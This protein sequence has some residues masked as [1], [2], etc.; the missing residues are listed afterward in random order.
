MMFMSPS[1]GKQSKISL[2]LRCPTPPLR[3]SRLFVSDILDSKMIE[4]VPPPFDDEK[5]S[6]S[7]QLSTTESPVLKPRP[8][9]GTDLGALPKLSRQWSLLKE[10]RE[11]SSIA[12]AITESY[13]PMKIKASK[14][15]PETS[16]SDS[17]ESSDQRNLMGLINDT[18]RISCYS[19]AA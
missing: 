1:P 19:K 10:Q 6:I 5:P 15:P 14:P 11:Q 8:R 2:E 18:E 4:I 9:Y 16:I 7:N 17:D 12:H 13:V 3:A